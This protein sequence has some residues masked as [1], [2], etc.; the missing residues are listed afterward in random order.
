[1][2]IESRRN[3]APSNPE[4][5]KFVMRTLLHIFRHAEK[6][7]GNDVS[8][9]EDLVMP[10]KPEGKLNSIKKGKETQHIEGAWSRA[11]G[12]PRQRAQETAAL[13]RAAHHPDIKGTESLAEI[14]ALLGEGGLYQG[15]DIDRR[16]DMPF[17]KG[18]TPE[19]D[20]LLEAYADG[21]YVKTAY[22]NYKNALEE[23][24]ND[25]TFGRQVR[26][27]AEL[28]A[29]H[30]GI[31][32]KLADRHDY[33]ADKPNP[34]KLPPALERFKSTHGG[35]AESFLVE[36]IRRTKGQDEAEKFLDFFPNGFNYNEGPDV[37]ITGTRDSEQQLHITLELTRGEKT[38]SLDETVPLTVVTEIVRDFSPPSTEAH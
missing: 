30:T 37:D 4:K 22:D 25:T 14:D 15:T 7:G 35:V 5:Q 18:E 9:E 17:I 31:N 23:T 8:Q 28:I 10:L 2:N 33:Y 21:H 34:E 12:S 26:N 20:A 19:F 29:W 11:V 16:L 3:A 1:M 6:A 13:R 32:R 38:Y 27:I 24:R 36:F